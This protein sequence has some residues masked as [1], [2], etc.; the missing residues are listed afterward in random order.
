MIKNYLTTAIRHLWRKKSFSLINI[1]G[2]AI[3]ISIS[4]LMLLYVLNEV[5]YDRF[6][7][8]SENIYRIA[9][10]VDAQGRT[11]MTPRVPVPF[12]PA[13]VEQFPEVLN[14]GRLRSTG[15]KIFSY[16]DKLF[17]ESRIYY[18]DSGIFDIFTLNLIGFKQCFPLLSSFR[19][20]CAV[21]G[22]F[23][24]P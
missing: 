2:L 3:G 12:G 23:R 11:L 22:L 13:L 1:A 20:S 6:N 16:E 7:E 17:K 5:T 10:K 8:N 9:L 14:T 18:A 19:T 24:P 21:I 4:L 15:G